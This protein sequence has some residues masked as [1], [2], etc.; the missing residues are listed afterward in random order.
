MPKAYDDENEFASEPAKELV[1]LSTW[2]R[3]RVIISGKHA[4][5][6]G[7]FL[8]GFLSLISS[9]FAVTTSSNVEQSIQRP[10]ARVG[11]MINEDAIDIARAHNE[12]RILLR[13]I[14]DGDTKKAIIDQLNIINRGAAR[15]KAMGDSFQKPLDEKRSSFS[16]ITTAHAQTPSPTKMTAEDVRLYGIIVILVVLGAAF[17]LCIGIILFSNHARRLTFAIDT[18]KVLM[19]FFV[20]VATSFFGVR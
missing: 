4:A 16:L 10:I 3:L 17:L 19:G 7:V 6:T 15:L 20:G 8:A 5:L 12:I 13:D 2:Q 18:T 11:T 1:G 14:P 9:F